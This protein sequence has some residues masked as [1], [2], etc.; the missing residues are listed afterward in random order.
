MGNQLVR[1]R[2]WYYRSMYDE[3]LLREVRRTFLICSFIYLP[4]Y[5]WGIHFN[6]ALEIDES[7]CYYTQHYL[8]RRLRLTH[9]LLFEEFETVLEDWQQL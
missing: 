4:A 5:W 9:S 1:N 8:P 6:R 2:F 3:Y 7:H